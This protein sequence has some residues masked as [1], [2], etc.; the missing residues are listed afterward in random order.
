MPPRHKKEPST[1]NILT[2]DDIVKRFNKNIL[3]KEENI[4]EEK[5]YKDFWIKADR[6]SWYREILNHTF[7]RP[8][9][10]AN[11][12][13]DLSRMGI[14][15]NDD[16]LLITIHDGFKRIARDDLLTIRFE[17]NVNAT[18]KMI[19]RAIGCRPTNFSSKLYLDRRF[20]MAW[21]VADRPI[22]RVNYIL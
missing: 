18:K 7:K 8:N 2:K 17:G 10:D 14:N 13:F 9:H 22:F 1:K 5:V 3:N 6:V 21:A 15:K 20:P 11:I 12:G 16:P 19:T 4:S